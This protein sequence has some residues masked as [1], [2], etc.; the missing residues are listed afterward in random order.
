MMPEF[1]GLFGP[2]ND[3]SGS[4]GKGELNMVDRISC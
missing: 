4:R 2:L 1:V 3:N